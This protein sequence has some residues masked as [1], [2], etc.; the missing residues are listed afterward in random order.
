MRADSRI[1]MALLPQVTA[2][3][4]S[5]SRFEPPAELVPAWSV[6]ISEDR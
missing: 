2:F 3:S 5:R 4:A 6:P 1:E